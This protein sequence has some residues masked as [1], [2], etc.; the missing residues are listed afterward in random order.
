MTS[1]DQLKTEQVN[2][3]NICDLPEI[4]QAE[5]IAENFSKISNE[6]EPIDP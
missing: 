5:F 4:D 2:V 1:H 6:Y 3:L